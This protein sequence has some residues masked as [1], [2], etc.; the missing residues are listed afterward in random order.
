MVNVTWKW[1]MQ[2]CSSVLEL[3]LIQFGFGQMVA[4]PLSAMN[5]WLRKKSNENQKLVA[6]SP[7]IVPIGITFAIGQVRKTVLSMFFGGCL[8][9]L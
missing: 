8:Y 2:K 1:A 7:H 6:M 3:T 4:I 9:F 5:L